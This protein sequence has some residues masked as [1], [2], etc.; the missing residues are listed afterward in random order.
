MTQNIFQHL[1]TSINKEIRNH[2]TQN[3]NIEKKRRKKAQKKNSTQNQKRNHN[4]QHQ[5]TKLYLPKQKTPT[6]MW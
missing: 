4:T 1:S 5:N 6:K 2:N 3:P